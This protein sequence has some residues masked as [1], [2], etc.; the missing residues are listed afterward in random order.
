MPYAGEMEFPRSCST[1]KRNCSRSAYQTSASNTVTTPYYESARFRIASASFMANRP[2]D[3]VSPVD[4]TGFSGWGESLDGPRWYA[5]PPGPMFMK[6]QAWGSSNL[7]P[8]PRD[9]TFF[10][11]NA[12]RS[13]ATR[14][15]CGDTESAFNGA[16]R[17]VPRGAVS[18]SAYAPVRDG[19]HTN[20]LS[21]GFGVPVILQLKRGP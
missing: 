20:Q 2:K 18:E 11:S 6:R 13:N 10:R 3:D 21:R 16:E 19:C 7:M 4:P 9:A 12:A 5:E 17:A 14:E 15:R 1:W 8:A